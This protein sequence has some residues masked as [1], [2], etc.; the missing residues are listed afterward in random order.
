MILYHVCAFENPPNGE[1]IYSARIMSHDIYGHVSAWTGRGNLRMC[2]MF[3][4]VMQANRLLLPPIVLNSQDY[5]LQLV[6][7]ACVCKEGVLKKPS[8]WLSIRRRMVRD[9]H[10]TP[11]GLVEV[12][13]VV[14]GL[15]TAAP[16]ATPC[17]HVYAPTSLGYAR[18]ECY[19]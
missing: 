10:G 5:T 16:A 12:V 6:L 15:P 13:E 1:G 18:Y 7:C 17:G 11:A 2:K 8:L 4:D 14:W 3:R 9:H 19:L